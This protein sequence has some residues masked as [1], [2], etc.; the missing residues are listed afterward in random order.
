VS[1]ILSLPVSPPVS[2]RWRKVLGDAAEQRGRLIMM[3]IAMAVGIFAVGLIATAYAILGRELDAGYLAT[4]PPAALLDVE[5]LDDAAVTGVRAR[6]G[7]VWAEAGSRVWGRIEVGPREWLPLLLIVRPTF[8]LQRIGRLDLERGQWPADGGGIALERTAVGLANSGVGQEVMVQSPSGSALRLA[9]TGIV[10]DPS[11]PPAG[12]QQAVYGYVTPATMRALG[13]T[14]PLKSLSVS[15]EQPAGGPAS[16]EPAS[17][18]PESVERTMVDVARWLQDSGHKVG[19]IR[20]PPRHHPHWGMMQNIVRLLLVLGVMTLALGAVL[21]ATVTATLLAPQARQIGVMKAIGARGAQITQLYAALIG[22]IGLAAVALGLPLG[23]FAGRRLASV[24]MRNQNIDVANLSIP[25]WLGLLLAVAGVGLPLL[26]ALI[27][28]LHATRRPV[29]EALNDYGVSLPPTVRRWMRGSRLTTAF[30]AATLGARNGMRRRGRLMLTLGLLATAGA[31][32]IANLNILAAWR[33][34]LIDARVERH[35]DIEIQFTEP[36]P[37]AAAVGAVLGV[38][39]TAQVESFSDEVAAPTRDDGLNFTRTFPDGGHGSLRLHAVPVE[40]AF[41]NPVS[42]SGRWLSPDEPDGAVLNLQALAFFPGL[43]LGDPIRVTVRGVALELRALGIIREH[44]AGATFY[45]SAETY[46]RALNEAD[47]TGGLR[48]ALQ[49]Q[50]ERLAVA[51]TSGIERSLTSVG[52]K[53]AGVTT[54]T[55]LGRALGGHLFMLIAILAFM[56]LLMAIVG[57][58][59]LGSTLGTSVLERAREFGVMRAIG[60]GDRSIRAV[61]LAEGMLIGVMSMVLA[62][63]A[64]VPLTFAVARVVGE[65][66]LGPARNTILSGYSIPL[67]LVVVLAGAT[68]A[69]L[70]PVRKAL[71][72]TVREALAYQ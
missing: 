60:A 62:A 67:W 12:Q 47:V 41:L 13:E 61:V 58:L 53:V 29:R 15:T 40:S 71:Q 38:P 7:V 45:V 30:P 14:P 59:G 8:A 24:V 5:A 64:S 27:P 35:A 11:L 10:H 22:L 39:G 33:H 34:S 6:P 65:A 36:Q 51:A 55:Q 46:R 42:R 28:I 63:V 25:G 31:L 2:P 9:V 3:L 23:I 4:N 43:K 50:N 44:L 37:T 69:S 49:S 70:G 17:G 66:S 19:E 48:V 20:I 54:R 32:F 21:T 26:F 57:L 68:V 52:I 1:R 18:S 56:A 72:V 16:G